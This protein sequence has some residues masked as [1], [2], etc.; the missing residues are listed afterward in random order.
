M[1]GNIQAML[2]ELGRAKVFT[3]T[4]AGAP[5]S[6]STGYATGFGYAGLGTR[7]INKSNGVVYV[8]EGTATTPYWTPLSFEQRGLIGGS[9]DFRSGLGKAVADTTASAIV[10]DGTGVRVFGQGIEQTDSGL[11][12]AYA[13]G[14]PVASLI[15]TDESAHLAAIGLGDSS[16]SMQPDNEGNMVIDAIVAMSSAI[17]LRSLFIGFLGTAAD[18]LDPPVTGSTTTLT[19]VQD[20][21]AGLVFDAGLTDADRIYAPYNKSDAAASIATTATGV[22]TGVDFPAAGTYCR[23]RVEINAD[24]T[25]VCFK[26]KAQITRI[27]SALDTD[28]ECIPVLLV[29]ST[30]AATKTML[31]K[32]FA[33]WGTRR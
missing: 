21:L 8:N 26:D 28:E 15:A 6:G 25:M 23:L 22:D 24:G 13:E 3:L 7:Y 33:A 2:A 32:Q 10:A 31:I 20:D 29:R 17:T 4:G 11:T 27:A 16:F 30:S 14:G 5:K 9:T 1:W 18:A 12:V 19:L